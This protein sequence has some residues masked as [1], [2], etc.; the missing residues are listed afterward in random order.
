[1]GL[2]EYDPVYDP[3]SACAEMECA[4]MG[5]DCGCPPFSACERSCAKSASL[6]LSPVKGSCCSASR[7]EGIAA[8]ETTEEGEVAATMLVQTW[9]GLDSAQQWTSVSQ[10]WVGSGTG[11]QRRSGSLVRPRRAAALRGVSCARHH[12]SSQRCWERGHLRLA[13]MA[14]AWNPEKFA[15]FGLREHPKRRPHVIAQSS[16]QPF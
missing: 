5:R 8:G 9:P 1:M 10:P 11:N 2:R 7:R 3:D 12:L 16:Q 4:R 6:V 13:W 14:L 15:A